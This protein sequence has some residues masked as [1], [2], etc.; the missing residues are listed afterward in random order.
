MQTFFLNEMSSILL[1]KFTNYGM[2]SFLASVLRDRVPSYKICLCDRDVLV[3]ILTWSSSFF[4]VS[5][6]GS[7]PDI[8][9]RKNGADFGFLGGSFGL[10]L[11]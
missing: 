6:F 8:V 9:G 7:S 11:S 5:N 4:E 10:F 1:L 2:K 3:K